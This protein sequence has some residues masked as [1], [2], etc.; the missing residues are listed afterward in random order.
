MGYFTSLYA[1]DL[2]HRAVAVYMYLRDR[3]DKNGKCYPAI[4]TISKELKLSRST[5]KR[6][7]ADLEKSG[8]LKKEKRWR[9]N[10]GRSSNMYYIQTL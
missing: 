10:G 6:A 3:A 7:I 1:S 4:G 9:E 8:R 2:P 5:V